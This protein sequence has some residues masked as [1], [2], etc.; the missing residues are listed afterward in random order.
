MKTFDFNYHRPP[1]PTCLEVFMVNNPVLRWPKPL[2]FGRFWG[3][4]VSIIYE[5]RIILLMTQ[6]S[7]KNI[8]VGSRWVDSLNNTAS[9]G[10]CLSTGKTSGVHEGLS[11]GSRHNNDFDYLPT[12]NQGFWQPPTCL[13]TGAGYFLQTKN[14]PMHWK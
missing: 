14:Q 8:P 1:K 11:L 3:L 12:V 13:S 9:I 6:V 7:K 10:P 5:N 4:M 2:F